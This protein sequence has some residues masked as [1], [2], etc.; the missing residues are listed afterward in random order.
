MVPVTVIWAGSDQHEI[1]AASRHRLKWR[2][3]LFSMEV[4]SQCVVLFCSPLYTDVNEATTWPAKVPRR[5]NRFAR[6]AV[7]IALPLEGM[8]E[9]IPRK[10]RCQGQY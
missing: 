8:A 5:E 6:Q 3:L 9:Y 2:T 1:T 7:A 10:T 4:T